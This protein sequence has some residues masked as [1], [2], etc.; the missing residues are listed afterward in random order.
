[1]DIAVIKKVVFRDMGYK[2]RDWKHSLKKSLKIKDNDSPET[3]RVRMTQDLISSYNPLDIDFLLDK[4]CSKA[5]KVGYDEFNYQFMLF[6]Y[7]T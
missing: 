2:F 5:N 6:N 7:L 1:M 3:I 4:W